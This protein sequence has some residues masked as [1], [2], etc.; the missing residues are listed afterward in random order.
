MLVAM[1]YFAATYT[2]GENAKLVSDT[3][4]AHREFIQSQLALGRILGSG[5]YVDGGQALIVLQLD[6]DASVADAETILDADPYVAA[7]ALASREVRE[8]NPVAN[9]FS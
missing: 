3:R 2:Y 7:G 8:W 6:D 4:P 5:P 9:T 1:K